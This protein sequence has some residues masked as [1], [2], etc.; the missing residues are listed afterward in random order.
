MDN[1]L[2]GILILVCVAAGIWAW[3]MENGPVSFGDGTG[4]KK[5]SESKEK[6]SEEDESRW[7]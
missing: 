2:V 7:K 6:E 4:E 5:E 1:V 3:W